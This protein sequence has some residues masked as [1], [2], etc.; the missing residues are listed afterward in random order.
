MNVSDGIEK[1]K[2][3]LVEN[4]VKLMETEPLKIVI[5]T[6]AAGMEGGKLAEELRKYKIEC[7]YADKY[8][9]VLM[10]T[11]QNDEK[12]FEQGLEKW[13]VKTKY[14]RDGRKRK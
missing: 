12:D 13:A 10:I 11:P 6:A 1:T 5:D 3:V 14:K 9:V 8:F 4:N 2:K 7:E